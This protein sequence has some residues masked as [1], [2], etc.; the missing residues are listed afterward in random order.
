MSSSG[1]VIIP[2]GL[3]PEVKDMGNARKDTESF[4][5]THFGGWVSD[6]KYGSQ[7]SARPTNDSS[8]C[9]TVGLDR[10]S[11]VIPLSPASPHEDRFNS[12]CSIHRYNC[13]HFR[14]YVI[15]KFKWTNSLP[16]SPEEAS[17]FRYLE[18]TA[19]FREEFCFFCSGNAKKAASAECLSASFI[20]KLTL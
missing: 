12:K 13:F 3:A 4:S 15:S 11:E 7:V 17:W 5:P 16:S 20:C 1:G 9:E 18:C 10:D 2:R 6:R 8:H 14:V 19:F